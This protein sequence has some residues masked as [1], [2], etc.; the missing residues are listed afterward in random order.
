MLRSISVLGLFVCCVL[1][2]NRAS[3]RLRDRKSVL[4]AF[5][6]DI[7]RISLLIDYTVMPLQNIVEKFSDSELSPFWIAFGKE[8]LVVHNAEQAWNNAMGEVL[9]EQS[10]LS[11][12][13]KEEL[14]VLSDFA[15]VLGKTDKHTQL[16]NISL[17]QKR[18]E[19]I[20]ADAQQQYQ[21][22]GR[23]YRSMGILCGAAISLLVI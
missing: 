9:K 10:L 22:K 8:L 16:L 5:L 23:L 20:L 3:G 13:M 7:Q 14:V 18:L 4:E 6:R 2:G 17:L 21:R 12:L 19:V 15:K 11:F 1:M